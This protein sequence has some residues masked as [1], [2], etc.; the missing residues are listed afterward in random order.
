MVYGAMVRKVW[1][2]SHGQP[3]WRSRSHA[4]TASRRAIGSWGSESAVGRSDAMGFALISVYRII[5]IM[6][7]I[8]RFE[9]TPYYQLIL[10]FAFKSAIS[11]R[12]RAASLAGT[13]KVTRTPSFGLPGLGTTRSNTTLGSLSPWALVAFS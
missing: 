2:T 5:Y 7:N 10:I 6:T 11:C 3:C 1:S 9:E 13:P 8:N 12:P 4:M